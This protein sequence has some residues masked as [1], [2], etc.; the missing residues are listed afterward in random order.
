MATLSLRPKSLGTATTP[1]PSL[2]GAYAKQ[3]LRT[4]LLHKYNAL[5]RGYQDVGTLPHVEPIPTPDNFRDHDGKVGEPFPGRICIVGAGVAG[6]FVAMILKYQGI[7]NFD[8]YEASDR[9]G[10]R[11]YTYEFPE[12]PNCPHNYY[13]IGAMRIPDIPWMQPTL[14]LIKILG[15]QTA[16]YVYNNPKTPFLYWYKRQEPDGSKFDNA[17]KLVVQPFLA[18]FNTAFEKWLQ[19]DSDNYSTRAWM[20][21]K[22][23][24]PLTYQETAMGELSD[25]STGLFDQAFTETICDYC[26]FAAATG[27]AW[28]RMDGGMSKVTDN[29]RGKL[30]STSWPNP[31][32]PAI[33]VTLNRPV[34]AMTD[35]GTTIGITSTDSQGKNPTTEKYTM[36]FNTTAMAPLQRMDIEGLQLPD[37]ILT[38]IRALSYDRATKVAIKFATPWWDGLYPPVGGVS[39]SDLPISNVVYPSWDDGP[40]K[41]AVLMVSYSWAQDATRMGAMVPDNYSD[42]SS[43]PT[44]D[45]PIVALCLQNLVKLFAGSTPAITLEYL[46]DCYR[47]HHAFAWSQDPYTGG[48]FALFGPG[49]FKGVYPHFQELY[50]N[51]KFAMCGEAL[52]AHH[53][54]IS[55]A[56]DSAYAMVLKFFLAHDMP[57]QAA[58]LKAGP[59]GGGQGVHPDEVDEALLQWT[60]K[61]S[62]G[63]DEAKKVRGR[64]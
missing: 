27:V 62:E 64:E 53:A 14:D 24:P 7:N 2:R 21:L 63:G 56:V 18:D 60:V 45:D 57:R 13:D 34:A 25:T 16:P 3:I 17:M 46:Y 32:S 61:L 1:I 36:V 9:A 33:N 5:N 50:C 4:H 55:G 20:V 49:Q 30:A 12:D 58:E 37:E 31:G 38:G 44:R 41:P 11:V 19:G 22:A 48:A 8:I 54:W 40:D 43:P 39:S 23:N 52:S 26:D 51:N 28:Y 6:L 35:Q 29:M 15:L 10:G 42:P 47:G 59:F